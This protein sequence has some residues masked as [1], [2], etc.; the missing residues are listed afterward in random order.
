MAIVLYRDPSLPNEFSRKPF[1][2]RW[3]T[4]PHL[5]RI[6]RPV[7]PEIWK[8]FNEVLG[9]FRRMELLGGSVCLHNSSMAARWVTTTTLS[10]DEI[11]SILNVTQLHVDESVR[12]ILLSMTLSLYYQHSWRSI[13]AAYLSFCCPMLIAFHVTAN[14]STPIR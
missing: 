14:Y 7:T 10:P 5:S 6:H 12:E 1:P 13:M 2:S 8:T 9:M 11:L 4:S 3:L